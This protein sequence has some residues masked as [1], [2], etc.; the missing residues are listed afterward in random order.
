MTLFTKNCLAS[1]EIAYLAVENGYWQVWLMDKDGNNA[2]PVTHTPYD[3]SSLSWFSNGDLLICGNQGEL[4]RFSLATQEET[5]IKLPF[6]YVND[7]VVS[8]NDKYI[9]FSQK[10]EGSIYNKLWLMNAATGKKVKVDWASEGFQHE[11]VFSSDSRKL[12][13]LSGNNR[14][15]HDIM[16]YDLLT[17][18]IKPVTN[19]ALYNLD[20][21]VNAKGQ[22]LYSSN[23]RGHYDIWYQDDKGVR[24]ITDHPSLD[25]RPAW[26]GDNLTIYFESSRGGVVNIWSVDAEARNPPVQI[27]HHK[28]GARYP[29]WNIK[30]GV[31]SYVAP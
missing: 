31:V 30:S 9:A 10:P 20:I 24:S 14:Q 23:R 21:A 15:S 25:G 28:V 18:Q 26:S 17:R 12:Y 16:E 29:L 6:K 1:D 22:F 4:V 7:A 11:P 3:K 5:T 27:T 2:R 13:Y 19:A 8:P